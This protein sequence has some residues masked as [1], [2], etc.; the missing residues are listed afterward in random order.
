MEYLKLGTI[1]KTRGLNGN[2]KIYSTSDFAY[3]R[4]Q[5]GN[6]V[7]LR[8]NED[9]SIKEFEVLDYSTDGNFDYVTFKGYESIEAISPFLKHDVLIIK[10]EHPLEDG[11]Y[12]HDDLKSCAIYE[13]NKKIAEVISIEEYSS[14][15]SLRIKFLHNNKEFLLP[16]IETFIKKID[17]ENR[18]I[19]VS[20]IEGMKE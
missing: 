20:L 10:E 7:F 17:I 2:V 14:Y 15:K 13:D 11:F 18:R 5:K 3:S 12:Y 9:N 1:I 19:D 8:N 6:K 4:Y 16:F